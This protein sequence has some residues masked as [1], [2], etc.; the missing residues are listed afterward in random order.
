MVQVTRAMRAQHQELLSWYVD[1]GRWE[2]AWK[3]LDLFEQVSADLDR[4]IP[5]AQVRPDFTDLPYWWVLRGIYWFA[6]L[7]D[8]AAYGAPG[9]VLT[10]VINAHWDVPRHVRAVDA[11]LPEA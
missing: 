3:Y 8:G 7:P 6:F 2:A 5:F 1:Q 9:P 10:S 11:V 4:G